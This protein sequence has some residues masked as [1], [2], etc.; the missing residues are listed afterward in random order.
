MVSTFRRTIDVDDLRMACADHTSQLLAT[1]S[2]I[3]CGQL[4]VVE[5][6]HSQRGGEPAASTLMVYN[7]LID[8]LQILPDVAG[9][10]MQTT[11]NGQDGIS[12]LYVCHKRESTV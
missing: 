2:D 3:A 8:L 12:V 9:H 10:D 5:H 11:A 6:H 1:G 7:K 4:E